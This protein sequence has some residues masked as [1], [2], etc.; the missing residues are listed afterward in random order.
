[1][2][3]T[4][5]RRPG[6]R[7]PRRATGRPERGRP[8][9]RRRAGRP[10]T[11]PPAPSA[12]HLE[13]GAGHVDQQQTLEEGQAGHQ[14]EAEVEADEEQPQGDDGD[15]GQAAQRVEGQRPA[16]VLVLPLAHLDHRLLDHPEVDDAQCQADAQAE[17]D[18]RGVEQ[19]A[20]DQAD[21]ADDQGGDDRA[22][23]DRG[24]VG[25]GELVEHLRCALRPGGGR[26]P[27]RYR[28]LRTW[29]TVSSTAQSTPKARPAKRQPGR[30]AEPRVQAV[31]DRPGP[32]HADGTGRAQPEEVPQPRG[33]L[34]RLRRGPGAA[35]PGSSAMP[36]PCRVSR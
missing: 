32:D 31:A 35:S 20:G 22:P 4:A 3:P 9:P 24:H 25:Q 18:Q 13:H 21:D 8:G 36:G 2:R 28:N 6:R 7:G 5:T 1:M 11:V 26:P 27:G 10:P 15:H 33:P 19:Q 29:T 17:A 23:R 34:G 30:E 12:P 16:L 14:P